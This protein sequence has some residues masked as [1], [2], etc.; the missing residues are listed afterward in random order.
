MKFKRKSEKLYIQTY[1]NE[2]EKLRILA[3]EDLICESCKSK[4]C[5]SDFGLRAPSKRQMLLH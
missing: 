1:F 3:F 5:M 2:K 4:N